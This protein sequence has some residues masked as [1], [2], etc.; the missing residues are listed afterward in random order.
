M[1][2]V[3]SRFRRTKLCSRNVRRVHSVVHPRD[4]AKG[5]FAQITLTC[6]KEKEIL[7][8]SRSSPH[9]NVVPGI[10]QKIGKNLHLVKNHPLNIIK[11]EIEGYFQ[12]DWA[13]KNGNF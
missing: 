7:E 5:V 4:Y 13:K 8:T 11:S 9:R 12:Q 3:V 2:Q 1:N 10:E 6:V